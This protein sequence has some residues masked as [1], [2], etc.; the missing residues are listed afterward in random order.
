[1]RDNFQLEMPESRER[2]EGQKFIQKTMVDICDHFGV[3]SSKDL[4]SKMCS[5]V[6]CILDETGLVEWETG[7][8]ENLRKAKRENIEYGYNP[9]FNY[10]QEK[11]LDICNYFNV[12]MDRRMLNEVEEI[13]YLIEVELFRY[14]HYT[15]KEIKIRTIDNE[16]KRVEMHKLLTLNNSYIGILNRINSRIEDID[17]D[18]MIVNYGSKFVPAADGN[19]INLDV[20]GSIESYSYMKKIQCLQLFNIM[21]VCAG[22]MYIKFTGI[23]DEIC[24]TAQRAVEEIINKSGKLM[25]MMFLSGKS[26]DIDAKKIVQEIVYR[27]SK[28]YSKLK[29]IDKP[30]L[31][32]W[33]ELDPFTGCAY[34]NDIKAYI[35]EGND[36]PR[37]YALSYIDYHT[38]FT[39]KSVDF[40]DENY[41]KKMGVQVLSEYGPT[42][43]MMRNYIK[44]KA[45]GL[46][47][48]EHDVKEIEN[49]VRRMG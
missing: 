47:I 4:A 28:D 11:L 34:E 17:L 2:R 37:A 49:R 12:S 42:W 18:N 45:A 1:M 10:V 20:Y 19:Y 43:K 24:I 33:V 15:D 41:F 26:D 31:P 30:A 8:I 5:N 14:T 13:L 6:T 16:I 38:Y 23:G 44:A 9:N 48:H 25:T 21:I 3:K 35:A 7:S 29:E 39:D 27:A 22:G 46:T 36:F 32:N 40:M